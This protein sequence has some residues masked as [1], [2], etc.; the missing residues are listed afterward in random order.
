MS[1]NR[2]QKSSRKEPSLAGIAFLAEKD[3]N[4]SAVSKVMLNGCCDNL[5]DRVMDFNMSRQTVEPVL[6]DPSEKNV[7]L[8]FKTIIRNGRAMAALWRKGLGF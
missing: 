4:V 2:L 1:D 3:P 8:A 7:D 5:V 6:A